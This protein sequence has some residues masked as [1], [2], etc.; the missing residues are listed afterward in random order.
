MNEET[1]TQENTEEPQEKEKFRLEIDYKQ[2]AIFTGP[3]LAFFIIFYS[4]QYFLIKEPPIKEIRS[5]IIK[6][7]ENEFAS[8][9]VDP[10]L[11]KAEVKAK[12]EAKIRADAIAEKRVAADGTV[13]FLSPDYKYFEFGGAISTNLIGSSKILTI[14]LS[15]AV[16]E[17]PMKAEDFYETFTFFVPVMRS[18]V[19]NAIGDLTLE[20]AKDETVMFELRNELLES[21]NRKL[22]DLG[23]EPI[24]RKIVFSNFVIT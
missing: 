2:L 9:N 4:A 13:T 17:T 24:L 1:P 12:V 15:L 23:S 19:I 7:D 5:E 6:K 22:R 20:L 11:L 3:A 8:L 10:P 14:N 18:I 16:F 21:F